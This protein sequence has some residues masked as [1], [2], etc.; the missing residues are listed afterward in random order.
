MRFGLICLKGVRGLGDRAF[1]PRGRGG[2]L[3]DGI[4]PGGGDGLGGRGGF[5]PRGGDRLCGRGLVA[6]G[7]SFELWLFRN[8][9]V[10]SEVLLR[11]LRRSRSV[12]AVHLRP[13]GLRQGHDAQIFLDET[14]LIRNI[15]YD[16]N[17]SRFAY[18][19]RSQELFFLMIARHEGQK[20]IQFF[21]GFVQKFEALRKGGEVSGGGLGVLVR[22][23]N[24]K[25]RWPALRLREGDLG[26]VGVAR[27]RPF[28]SL[29]QTIHVHRGQIDKVGLRIDRFGLRRRR[30]GSGGARAGG[31]GE[32]LNAIFHDRVDVLGQLSLTL[33]PLPVESVLARQ[34]PAFHLIHVE[35]PY[36]PKEN[37]QVQGVALSPI[38]GLEGEVDD[39]L[40]AKRILEFPH[41]LIEK[42]RGFEVQKIEEALLESRGRRV[43]AIGL[44]RKPEGASELEAVPA[45]NVVLRQKVPQIFARGL[46]DLKVRAQQPRREFLHE[47]SDLLVDREALRKSRGNSQARWLQRIVSIGFRATRHAFEREESVEVPSDLPPHESGRDVDDFKLHGTPRHHVSGPLPENH[48]ENESLKLLALASVDHLLFFAMEFAHQIS[49]VVL[50]LNQRFHFL[51]PRDFQ[52]RS[53]GLEVDLQGRLGDLRKNLA[54]K[55]QDFVSLVLGVEGA[56][57]V[58]D[59]RET[60]RQNSH[61]VARNR[62]PFARP[63]QNSDH[64]PREPLFRPVENL[65]FV[66][67]FRH[68]QRNAEQRLVAP[69]DQGIGKIPDGQTPVDHRVG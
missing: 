20:I 29:G 63:A 61:R 64:E 19:L 34:L 37:D 2:C 68:G 16:L 67:F 59:L 35:S 9:F 43:V 18:L 17:G 11:S 42:P 36:R 3:N 55:V 4:S 30:L 27:P 32:N 48:S 33:E 38:R 5:S 62:R 7:R 52:E 6:P 45:E 65:R 1:S 57:H 58:L 41:A 31:V 25:Q 50:D 46:A 56:R 47:A 26:E 13:R 39:P 49:Q 12:F 40:R 69:S 54:S 44:L 22:E 66:F 8:W 21:E 51:G 53:Q 60:R 28:G 23:V 14:G 15:N 24:R 10:G